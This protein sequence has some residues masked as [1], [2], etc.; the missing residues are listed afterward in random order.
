MKRA[1]L[2]R[3]ALQVLLVLSLGF[4]AGV[5][6][7]RWSQSRAVAA[8]QRARPAQ[9]GACPTVCPNCTCEEGPDAR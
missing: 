8:S 9:C 5:L 4:V 3:T 2:A 6:L 1:K 7:D